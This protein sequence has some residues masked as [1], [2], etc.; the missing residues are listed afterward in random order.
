[1]VIIVFTDLTI[2][3]IYIPPS[4]VAQVVPY[5]FTA[6]GAFDD[7]DLGALIVQDSGTVVNFWVDV[8]ADTCSVITWF[9]N[10]TQLGPS[11]ETFT[12]DDPCH[13]AAPGSSPNWRFNLAV[14]LMDR[15][16]GSYT[17]T[18]TNIAETVTLPTPAYFTVPG[19]WILCVVFLLSLSLSIFFFS[20]SF[21]LSL[22]MVQLVY[23][24]KLKR[25]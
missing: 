14:M 8:I 17:A 5:N 4:V 6:L 23:I 3:C 19:T 9:F 24:I 25:R 10:G 18:F 13:N 21:F 15:T 16:S 11:N 20:L 7:R 12:Y 1:M 22:G 2:Y